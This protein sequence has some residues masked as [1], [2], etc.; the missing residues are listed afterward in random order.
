[1][2]ELWIV[3]TK[4]YRH[5]VSTYYYIYYGKRPKCTK[6]KIPDEVKHLFT[7][8]GLFAGHYNPKTKALVEWSGGDMFDNHTFVCGEAME[9]IFPQ[10]KKMRVNTCRKIALTAKFL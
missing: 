8:D 3:K 4:M 10:L 2:S 7:K 6:T 5:S 9:Q 1:M